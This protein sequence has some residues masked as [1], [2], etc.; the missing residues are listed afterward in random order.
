[1]VEPLSLANKLY[2]PG[3]GTVVEFDYNIEDDEIIQTTRLVSLELNGQKVTR[4][5]PASGFAGTNAGGRFVGG[6]ASDGEATID[7]AGPVV[8]PGSAFEDDLHV[9]TPDAV[10]VVDSVLEGDASIRTR[11]TLSLR[12]VTAEKTIQLAGNPDDAFIFDSDIDTFK[13]SFGSGD[14]T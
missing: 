7:A 6:P 9:H 13:A 10:V 4:V 3:V 14:D 12:G 8:L 5:V 11:D 2:A 1:M